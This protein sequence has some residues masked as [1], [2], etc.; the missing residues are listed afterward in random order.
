MKI[1]YWN[2]FA[3]LPKYTLFAYL[4]SDGLI[5]D[6]LSLLI[7]EETIYQDDGNPIDFFYMRV[8]ASTDYQ[9]PSEMV[10]NIGVG[11]RDGLFDNHRKWLIYDCADMAQMMHVMNWD[12]H[13]T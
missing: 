9:G 10:H 11:E 7:K 1:V 12:V 6:D 4:N 13:S 2:E 3:L 8:A 5:E